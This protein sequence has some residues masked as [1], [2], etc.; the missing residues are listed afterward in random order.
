[1]LT[2]TAMVRI[3]AWFTGLGLTLFGSTAFAAD[4]IKI[5]VIEPLSG[6]FANIGQS[7]LKHYQA[8]VEQANRYGGAL[9]VKLE[10]VPFDNKSSPQEALINLQAAIDQGIRYV[11]Q[12]SGSNVAHAL[13][14]AMHAT[15]DDG[16]TADWG[17]WLMP[18]IASYDGVFY[19]E[20]P[21]PG[22]FQERKVV[23]QIRADLGVEVEVTNPRTGAGGDLIYQYRGPRALLLVVIARWADV[24][25]AELQALDTQRRLLPLDLRARKPSFLVAPADRI[26]DR[27][28]DTPRREVAL[29]H[30]PEYVIHAG[31]QAAGHR[32]GERTGSQQLRAADTGTAI[33]RFETYVGQS[34]VVHELDVGVGVLPVVTRERDVVSRRERALDRGIDIER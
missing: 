25:R 3:A 19:T 7:S 15:I 30:L 13:R 8:A 21:M 1:M 33:R 31:A 16:T 2:R 4:T 24:G 10:I 23:E 28:A 9:G 22:D 12:A 34:L 26:A 17:L 18:L 27:D 29:E 5:G 32:A 6:P 11:T 14:D 20:E